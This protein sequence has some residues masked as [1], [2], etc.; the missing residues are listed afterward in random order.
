MSDASR[1]RRLAV[2]DEGFVFDPATGQSFLLN[3]TGL[4]IFHGLQADLSEEELT[5]RV[6]DEFDVDP[7]QAAVDVEEFLAHLRGLQILAAVDS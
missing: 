3:A 6:I 5:Q 4:V 1:V 7:D 2:S